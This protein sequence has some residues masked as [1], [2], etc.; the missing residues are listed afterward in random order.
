MEEKSNYNSKVLTRFDLRDALLKLKKMQHPDCAGDLLYK[1]EFGKLYLQ[2]DPNKA[3]VKKSGHTLAY[4]E[5]DQGVYVLDINDCL[6]YNDYLKEE[7][8][9][10]IV[11]DDDSKFLSQRFLKNAKVAYTYAEYELRETK[12]ADLCI[13]KFDSAIGSAECL[14]LTIMQVMTSMYG[15]VDENILDF[16]I[17]MA[18]YY[19]AGNYSKPGVKLEDIAGVEYMSAYKKLTS[20]LIELAGQQLTRNTIYD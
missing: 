8:A 3:L 11:I 13:L 14:L 15:D 16:F 6:D 18:N 20:Y 7:M 10:V 12:N 4:I 1:N 19:F 9:S 2:Y 17:D 5:N